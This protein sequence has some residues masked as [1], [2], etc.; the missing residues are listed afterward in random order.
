[1]FSKCK[2]ISLKAP[3]SPVDIIGDRQAAIHHAIH[4]A[5]ADDIVVIAGKGH[6]EYQEIKGKRLPFSDIEQATQ[7]LSNW[8]R[9][10]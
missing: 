4:E 5:G 9:H 7:A 2:L 10:D 3:A 6:E 1:M 8:S